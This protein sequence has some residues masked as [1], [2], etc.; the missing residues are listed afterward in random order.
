LEKKRRDLRDRGRS[1]DAPEITALVE[2]VTQL[3][4]QWEETALPRDRV[5]AVLN[6]A[7]KAKFAAFE[8]DLELAREAVELHLIRQT[9]EDLAEVLCH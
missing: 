6:D 4:K 9:R 5:L 3:R 2:E 1:E 8:S 7:Q